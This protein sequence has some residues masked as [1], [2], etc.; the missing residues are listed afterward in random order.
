MRDKL[1]NVV[2][3]QTDSIDWNKQG[4]IFIPWHQ[5][6]HWQLVVI[7]MTKSALELHFWDSLG[8]KSDFAVVST[9]VI[10]LNDTDSKVDFKL[11]TKKESL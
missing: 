5:P 1:L 3:Q 11:I 7:D 8:G 9:N 6:G 2:K 10:N 4:L